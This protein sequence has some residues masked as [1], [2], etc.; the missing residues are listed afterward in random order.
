MSEEDNGASML[1]PYIIDDA[2]R[3]RQCRFMWAIF[4][5]SYRVLPSPAYQQHSSIFTL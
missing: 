3:C 5:V 4:A 1:S 2:V